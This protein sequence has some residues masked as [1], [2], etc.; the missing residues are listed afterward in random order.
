MSYSGSTLEALTGWPNCESPC[1]YHTDLDDFIDIAQTATNAQGG[2]TST[3]IFEA[4]D[5]DEWESVTMTAFIAV[6]SDDEDSATCS[7]SIADTRDDWYVNH[8]HYTGDDLYTTWA[9]PEFEG[10]GQFIIA[11]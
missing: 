8:A 5:V 11:A 9:I 1:I 7:T 2:H 6:C 3:I 10:E 4:S